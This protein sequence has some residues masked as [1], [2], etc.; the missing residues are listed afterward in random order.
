MRDRKDAKIFEEKIKRR[1]ILKFVILS[2][3]LTFFLW[4][5]LKFDKEWNIYSIFFDMLDLTHCV[6]SS[7]FAP[8][9]GSQTICFSTLWQA[10]FFK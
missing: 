4:L 10:Y 3:I 9:L 6:L 8:L 2:W 1:N 5:S 7:I